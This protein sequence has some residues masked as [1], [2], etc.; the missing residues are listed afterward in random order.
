MIVSFGTWAVYFAFAGWAV[1]ALL[2]ATMAPWWRSGI[3]RNMLAL[4]LVLAAT[5]GLATVQLAWGVQWPARDWVRLAVF[6]AVASIG[7]WRSF[8]LLTDQVFAVRQP[9]PEAARRLGA[10]HRAV[11]GECGK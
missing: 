3:G 4:A 9:M 7:W 8:I 5:L 11:C 6:A 10:T 1:F 2:Y